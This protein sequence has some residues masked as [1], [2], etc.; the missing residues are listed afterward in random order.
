MRAVAIAEKIA[1]PSADPES[2]GGVEQ[3]GGEAGLVGGTPALAAVVT[4]TNTAPRPSAMIEQ[5]GQQVGEVGAVDR[6][7][8]EP[9][10]RRR[11]RAA[12]RR[13]SSAGCRCART[14][15]ETMP[16]EIADADGDR[17]VGG[18]GLDRRVAAARSACTA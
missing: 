9:V 11:R 2:L 18:A 12:R 1:S 5:A 13:R 15:G 3:P 6:D 16:A 8:G 17:E 7:A 4:P 14:A 10:D